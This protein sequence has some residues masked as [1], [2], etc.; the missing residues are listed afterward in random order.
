MSDTPEN[1][2][3]SV[4]KDPV[5][6]QFFQA[7]QNNPDQFFQTI[8]SMQNELNAFRSA[9]TNASASTP[10]SETHASTPLLPLPIDPQILLLLDRLTQKSASASAPRSEK[11]PDILEYDGDEAKLDDWEQTLVHRMHVNHD[12]YP[13]D[14]TKISYAESRLTMGKRAHLLM[15]QYRVDGLCVLSSFADWRS[16]LRLACG[17]P[18]EQ[19]DA[20][21]YLRETLKQGSMTF[22]EYHNLFT[23]MKER[24]R[25]EDA[26]LIDAMKANINYATQAAAIHYRLPETNR[27]PVTFDE[28][29][30]MW[31]ETDRKIRQLKHTLPRST[32]AASNASSVSAPKKST[33]TIIT[34]TAKVAPAPS[35]SS[36]LIPAAPAVSLPPGEPMDLSSATA[37]VKG[38]SLKVPGVKRICDVWKLCYYCKLSHPGATAINCPYKG[39]KPDA[40]ARAMVLY[41]D[42]AS[43]PSAP[44]ENV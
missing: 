28:H 2:D 8:Q 43:E 1:P 20:R 41:Q 4:P 17:N 38:L 22:E 42:P 40:N 18:F 44:A 33:T 10:P 26:S 19:E 14:Q 35:S 34:T 13:S 36:A 23:Q 29:V 3:P 39:K 16:K 12:R 27:E 5:K 15:G 25:M 21:R 32:T 6:T 37:A 7:F 31:S 24:S 11:L 30:R 9:S